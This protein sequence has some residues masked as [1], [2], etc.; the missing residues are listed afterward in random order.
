MLERA[1]LG[2]SFGWLWSAY[3]VSAYGTGLG[4]GA[5]SYVAITVLGAS[6]GEV[7]ALS[8]AGLAAG[9]VLAVPL[10]PWVEFRRKRPV[11]ITMDLARFLALATIPLALW[12]GV[13]TLVQLLVVSVVTAA[14]K[15]AFNAASGSYLKGLVP[16]EHLLTASS[17]FES[18]TWSATVVG[19]VVGGAAMG[20]I[21][22]VATVLADAASYLLSALGITAI[23]GDEPAVPT[24]AERT[25]FAD[26][27]LGWRW[28]WADRTLRRVFLNVV[29]VNALIMAAEPLLT[30]MMLGPLGFPPWQYGLAFALPC[31]GGLVGS[32]LARR[33]VARYGQTAVLLRLGAV[34]ALWP[35]GLAF[36]RPGWSGLVIVM[37]VELALI[38]CISLHNPVVGTYR[39]QVVD[40]DRLAR[41]LAAWSV[42][43]SAGIAAVTALWGVLATVTS[44]RVGIAAAGVL[45][46]ATPALL[47]RRGK[48]PT[49]PAG[50]QARTASQSSSTAPALSSRSTG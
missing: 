16:P 19:P 35:I 4:F 30:F 45:L 11:M 37:A 20:V 22:P 40:P 42:T 2:R 18:T 15:I 44:P 46:L 7:S 28:I 26:L 43:T 9:A 8:V 12:L 13:L 25:R 6:A 1:R 21:G 32:R 48:P 50:S 10:G 47:P 31:L 23:R 34:R 27:L 36:V 24:R 29:A 3:A 5:F 17:R 14:A 38:G 39:M 49:Q 33:V 41:V